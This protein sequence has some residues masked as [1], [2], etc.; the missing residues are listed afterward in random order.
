MRLGSIVAC[1][2]AAPLLIG[3][4]QP[5]RLQPSS[6]WVVDYAAN[7]CRLV[8]TFGEGKNT[9]KLAFESA[10]PGEVDMLVFGKPLSTFDEKVAAR[11]LP[12]G[13]KPFDGRVAETVTNGD[14]AIL[15]SHF[16]MLP[17]AFAEKLDAKDRER[18]EH[19]GVRPP[20]ISL[21]DQEERKSQR[22]A[23]AA[24]ATALEIE[25][26]RNRTVILET[27]SLG[28]AI[29][30]FDE[31]GRESLRDWGVDPDLN[32]K[33][34]RPAWAVNPNQWLFESDYPTD[35][36]RRGK[37]SEVAV[38]LLIDATGKVTS[39]TS[40][41]HF[42]EEEFNRITCDRIKERARFEPAELSD[43]T[44]VPDYYTRRVVFRI[45]H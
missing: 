32:D 15:W 29:A 9:T 39:C 31:C 28:A 38:R 12:V 17:Q 6:P 41:S 30:K 25:P 18:R 40:L 23:F 21:A 14:P 34:V 36:L 22:R 24:A 4:A 10:A 5:L 1:A 35:M 43:G 7:S 45:A 2:A 20:P 44:K 19:P 13:G 33:I 3:A 26:R 42:A 8:R 16:R 11:F 37:E 27:G